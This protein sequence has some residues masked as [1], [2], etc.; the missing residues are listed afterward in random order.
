MYLG[1]EAA[2]WFAL[3]ASLLRPRP[4]PRTPFPQFSIPQSEK[5]K[6]AETER[7]KQ[8]SHF[9]LPYVEYVGLSE[10]L[11]LASELTANA[12]QEKIQEKTVHI[13][14]A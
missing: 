5:K 7:E 4:R 11:F 6:L 2:R 8:K 13:S 12:P 9:T 14:S 10:I 3:A 1:D